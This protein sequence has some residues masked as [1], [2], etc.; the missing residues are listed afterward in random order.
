MA[1]NVRTNIVLIGFMGAGKTAAAKELARLTQMTW[2]D[3]DHLVENSAQMPISM[4][5]EKHGEGHLRCLEYELCQKLANGSFWHTVIATG[6]GIVLNSKN[7]DALGRC[8]VVFYLKASADKLAANLAGNT[9]NPRP[10]LAQVPKDERPQAI[11]SLLAVR[12]PLYI[13]AADHVIDTENLSPTGIAVAILKYF[14]QANLPRHL[15]C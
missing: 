8:A 2:I 9:S 4:I 1:K 14:P 6:G 7:T 12:E 10:L 15:R 3:T 5:F 11:A 13:R